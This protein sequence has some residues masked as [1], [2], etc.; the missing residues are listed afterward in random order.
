MAGARWPDGGEPG[1]ADMVRTGSHHLR[2][3]SGDTADAEAV[4][5]VTRIHKTLIWERTRTTQRLR[6]A[7]LDYFP[8]ALEAFEDLDAP[9]VLEL[10]ANSPDPTAAAKL[11][12]TQISA[13]LKRARRRNIADKATRI[14][15]VLRAKHLGQPAAVTAAYADSVRALG[16]VLAITSEAR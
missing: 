3:I 6:H 4:K 13:A 2:P 7:L 1:V 14:Q 5:V 12:I 9:D 11:T 15:A 16:S 8:A 10:L